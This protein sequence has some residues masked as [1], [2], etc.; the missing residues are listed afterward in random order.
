MGQGLIILESFMRREAQEESTYY[1][2]GKF[3]EAS[4]PSREN[5]SSNLHPGTLTK[6]DDYER[7]IEPG[8]Q[9]QGYITEAFKVSSC[10]KEN[11]EKKKG[12]ITD[13]SKI[14]R[15]TRFYGIVLQWIK[16]LLTKALLRG[17]RNLSTPSSP[18]GKGQTRCQK[19]VP[20][21]GPRLPHSATIRSIR[22]WIGPRRDSYSAC[23]AQIYM[24]RAAL[25]N[26]GEAARLQTGS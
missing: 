12:Q 14:E 6:D 23:R 7:M 3:V 11:K 10:S 13:Q 15:V 4:D 21:D 18:C 5:L 20:C 2:I 9:L 22:F 8:S 24:Q 17:Q 19:T 16:A 26:G 1:G 25:S